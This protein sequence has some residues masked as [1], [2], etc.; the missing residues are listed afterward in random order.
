[1][2]TIRKEMNFLRVLEKIYNGLILIVKL[3]LSLKNA[4]KK[5]KKESLETNKV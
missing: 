3:K 2:L 1:M 4:L 5:S